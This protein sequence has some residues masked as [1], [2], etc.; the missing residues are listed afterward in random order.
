MQGHARGPVQRKK[1]TQTR[2]R[3]RIHTQQGTSSRDCQARSAIPWGRVQTRPEATAPYAA[4]LPSHS[5]ADRLYKWHQ[6]ASWLH[7]AAQRL[8]PWRPSSAPPMPSPPRSPSPHLPQRF[9]YADYHSL[10]AL[11]RTFWRSQSSNYAQHRGRRPSLRPLQRHR[12]RH[13][14][15]PPLVSSSSSSLSCKLF[16]LPFP[17]NVPCPSSM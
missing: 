9:N 5:W 17:T 1:K 10:T 8:A 2:G 13:P 3:R 16:L 14:L 6:P 12:R 15:H 7:W 4:R 11:L